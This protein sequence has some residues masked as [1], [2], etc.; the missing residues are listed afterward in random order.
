MERVGA[1]LC[2]YVDLAAAEISKLGI[3]VIRD[4]AELR[5]RVKVGDKRSPI[6]NAFFRIRAIDQKPFDSG[7]PPLTD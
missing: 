2:D 5:D 6:V 7:V 1:G 4:D 3:E